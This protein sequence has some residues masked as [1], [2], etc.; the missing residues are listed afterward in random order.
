MRRPCISRIVVLPQFTPLRICLLIVLYDP[1]SRSD[2][3]N[4]YSVTEFSKKV[5][6][7][8]WGSWNMTNLES[9]FGAD[10]TKKKHI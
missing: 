4:L 5:L 3:S 6:V 7:E 10:V 8:G 1:W 2:H 9:G